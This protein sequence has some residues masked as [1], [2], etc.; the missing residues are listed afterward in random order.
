[1]KIMK[2]LIGAIGALT[3]ATIVMPMFLSDNHLNLI[4]AVMIGIALQLYADWFC[5]F[6]VVV[7]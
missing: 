2:Y 3:L 4:L 6:G 7:D 1:M 5:D